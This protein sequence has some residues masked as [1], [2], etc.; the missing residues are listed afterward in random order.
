MT[1]IKFT[2]P[3]PIPKSEFNIIHQDPVLLFGSCFTESIGQKLLENK[4]NININPNGIIYNPISV[5]SALQRIIDGQL[6]TEN[7]LLHFNGKWLSLNHHGSFSSLEKADCLNKIN[8]SVTK[9]HEQ[10]SKAKIVIITFGSAWVYEYKEKGI[11][12][13]CHKI[14]AKEF[15]KR[16]LNVGEIVEHFNTMFTALK[17]INP[18]IKIVLTI[19][20]V[21]HV[22][23]GLHENN[24][25]K[26]VLHLATDNIIKQNQNCSYF[27][28]YELVIDE[29]RDYRFFKDD[30]VHPS[31][32]AVNYVWEKFCATFFD[33]D[34]MLLNEAI[35]KVRNAAHHNPFNAKSETHQKFVAALLETITKIQEDF[36]FLDFEEEKNLI[37]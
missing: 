12:A 4:F 30:L 32:M 13:N 1:A 29:L 37:H 2:T 11:V 15:T 6:Y 26:S 20:P 36:P 9:A 27:P 21:R 28:A 17:T 24:L 10:L 35:K 19:S 5:I 7:E 14:P 22:G 3:V 18:Q 16:L 8:T 34:T 25:S 33:E 23:D 31:Q